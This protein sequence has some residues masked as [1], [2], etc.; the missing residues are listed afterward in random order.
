MLHDLALGRPLMSQLWRAAGSIP[1]N[2]AEGFSRGTGADR[3]RFYE[4]ALGSARECVVWYEAAREI[5]PDD[6]ISERVE[7]LVRVK[8][9]LLSLLPSTR[10]LN[11]RA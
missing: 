7:N 1:A 10:R 11:I 5:L 4:Y 8:R 2:L 3:A 6:L 9:L